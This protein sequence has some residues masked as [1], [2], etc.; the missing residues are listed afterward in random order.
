M[1]ETISTGSDKCQHYIQIL[2]ME[3]YVL[4]VHDFTNSFSI[5]SAF[6]WYQWSNL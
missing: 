2:V 1:I 6:T 4:H 5:S 3:M